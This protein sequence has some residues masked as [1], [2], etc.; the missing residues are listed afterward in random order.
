MKIIIISDLH[1][2]DAA[3]SNEFSVGSSNNA[4]KNQ[5]LNELRQLSNQEDIRADYLVVAG[6]IT[7]RA[8]REEFE[9]ASTRLKEIAEIVGVEQE[10]VFFVPGN[11]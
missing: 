5:F 11:H 10:K 8:T 4:V 3:V 1:V 9:L 7:N 2:G 6:D